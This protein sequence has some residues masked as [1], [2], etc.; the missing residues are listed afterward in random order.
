MTTA[1]PGIAQRPGPRLAASP[2]Q[3]LR[4]SVWPTA[5]RDARSQRRG[6]YLPE[7]VAHPAKMLPAIA[8][9]AITR[10]TKP[11]DLVADPMCGIGTTLVEAVHLGREGLG[12]EYEE[13]WATLAAANVAHAR[14]HGAAGTA[15]VIRGDA[16]QFPALLPPGMAGRAALV[17]TSP[18]Y[19]PSVHGQV[20]AE[21]RRGQGG[22][23][24]KFDNRYGHDPANLAHQGLDELLAGFTAILAGC[25]VLLR[26]GGLAV[27]TARPWR[28]HGEL[29]DLPAAVIAAGARAGLVPAAR[30]VALLAGL[31]GGRL[32]ARP[33]FFQLENLRRARRRGQPWHLIVHEDVLIFRNPPD[34][35]SSGEL[36]RAQREP[37]CL[38]PSPVPGPAGDQAA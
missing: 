15:Q 21:Q 11:G 6:R 12:V 19:G 29:I 13:R 24:H 37:T 10:Y 7:S 35:S 9:T 3:D 33:S 14:R 31:R 5:Q 4:L 27:V 25:A 2:D 20:K 8:A 17:V 18:P 30:C 38:S 1:Q 22:G 28:H 34:G 26:P 32:I 23:V 36:N 16:R